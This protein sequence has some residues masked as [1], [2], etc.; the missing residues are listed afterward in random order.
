MKIIL[1]DDHALVR[2]GL[3]LLL[4]A[5][6]PASD[7][8]ESA[9]FGE[10]ITQLTTD[11]RA[12]LILLDY[13]MADMQ[14]ADGIR[15]VKRCAPLAPLIVVSAHTDTHAHQTAFDAGAA[16]FVEKTNAHERLIDAI[17]RV[18]EGE[19]VFPARVKNDAQDHTLTP[20]ED[21]ISAL[22]PRQQQVLALLGRGL[23]NKDIAAEIG[24]SVGT[25]KVYLNAIYRAMGVQNRTQA[26]LVAKQASEQTKRS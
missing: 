25:V 24:I 3:K 16:G 22:T 5:L 11:R 19:K 9:S 8:V 6:F 1:A 10:V 15:A 12:D 26:A 18:M 23:S 17:K 2:D 21:D 7:I 13:T 20:D 14:A 4:E